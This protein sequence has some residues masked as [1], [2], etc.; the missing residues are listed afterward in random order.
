[1][2][3]GCGLCGGSEQI[4]EYV[5]TAHILSKGGVVGGGGGELTEQTA[6]AHCPKNNLNLRIQTEPVTD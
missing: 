3:V 4:F 1:M 6:A 5:G 2:C